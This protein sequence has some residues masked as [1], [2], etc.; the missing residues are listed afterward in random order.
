MHSFESPKLKYYSSRTVAMANFDDVDSNNSSSEN[1]SGDDEINDY[2]SSTSSGVRH[3]RSHHHSENNSN[4]D[5]NYA[6][7]KHFHVPTTI[8]SSHTLRRVLSECRALLSIAIPIILGYV[9]F[10]TLG[11]TCLVIA[12]HS[13]T[14][15]QV[16]GFSLCIVWT[17]ISTIAISSGFVGTVID[18][19][20][21][22]EVG[23]RGVRSPHLPHY[24]VS[25]LVG[26]VPFQILFLFSAVTA[27]TWLAWC[28]QDEGV[29]AAATAAMSYSKY[30][31]LPFMLFEA[32]RR[33]LQAQDRAVPGSVCMGISALLHPVLTMFLTKYFG[34]EGLA[35]AYTFSLCLPSVLLFC[36]LYVSTGEARV[37]FAGLRHNVCH[38]LS[39]R[40]LLATIYSL[41]VPGI[42]LSIGEMIV[43]D[44][45]LIATGWFGPEQQAAFSLLD[46]TSNLLYMVPVGIGGAAA[47]RV[48]TELGRRKGRER[49]VAKVIVGMTFVWAAL[50]CAAILALR[51]QLVGL[52]TSDQHIQRLLSTLYLILAPFEFADNAQAVGQ[53]ILRGVGQQHLGMMINI[54]VFY[55][56]VVPASLYV[57]FTLQYHV[58]GLYAVVALGQ[59][60]AA[61]AMMTALC[62]VPWKPMEG[63]AENFSTMMTDIGDFSRSSDGG[64]SHQNRYEN[65]HDE[66]QKEKNLYGTFV[67]S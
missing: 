17:D 38:I 26:G 21:T 56:I 54:C 30:A 11:F 61:G 43:F 29:I 3:Y 40:S 25:A 67:G 28:G 53:G 59:F 14:P 57:G 6:V 31:A 16:A 10:M 15:Q 35:M 47:V 44:I 48:G 49:R 39:H 8:F 20:C 34:F 51:L 62:V 42:F 41:G 55:P 27:T 64:N 2:K 13:L 32:L 4:K 22:Q 1:N 7:D 19:L 60:V 63:V 33:Q 58:V 23:A 24:L 45:A 36:Y 52:F 65:D 37:W 18:T 9:G 46:Q 12:G 5:Y 50:M 66:N